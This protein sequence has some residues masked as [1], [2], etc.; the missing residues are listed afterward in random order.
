[1]D[2][3]YSKRNDTPTFF[4]H[5]IYIFI[6]LSYKF[7]IEFVEPNVC[8]INLMLDLKMRCIRALT[9]DY[10]FSPLGYNR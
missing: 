6:L 4:I 8:P 10:L 5:L 2:Q 1:M 3:N 7:I 9:M